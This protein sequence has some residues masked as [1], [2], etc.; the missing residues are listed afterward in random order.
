[1]E[2]RIEDLKRVT[3]LGQEFVMNMT[4]FA[5]FQEQ[6]RKVV[7]IEL[8]E[9]T[10]KSDA[11]TQ[12]HDV[13]TQEPAEITQEHD[14]ITQ[15][16]IKELTVSHNISE[17]TLKNEVTP[18]PPAA[19]KIDHKAITNTV[20]KGYTGKDL[21]KYVRM[22]EAGDPMDAIRNAM[23][24]DGFCPQSTLKYFVKKILAKSTKVTVVHQ[25]DITDDERI[26]RLMAKDLANAKNRKK[27]MNISV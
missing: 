25:E 5:A 19:K 24:K 13:I 2:I 21:T 7:E 8:S 16:P 18:V 9:I 17:E 12:E 3:M 4:E 6:C 20:K 26:E 11:I 14:E 1:M 10:D 27:P 22:H 23:L 15:E